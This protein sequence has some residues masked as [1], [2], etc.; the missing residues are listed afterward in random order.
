MKKYEKES[1]AFY[2]SARLWD[3]G[4]INPA[5]TRQVQHYMY[6]QRDRILIC[7]VVDV[8]IGYVFCCGIEEYPHSDQLWSIQ[9]VSR[10]PLTP[11]GVWLSDHGEMDLIE[12]LVHQL[13]Y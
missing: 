9:N 13:G 7:G 6:L 8:G 11:G 3:D 5:H 4:V 12:G 2:A 10:K 1:H